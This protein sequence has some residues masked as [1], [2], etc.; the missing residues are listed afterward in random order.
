MV[1]FPQAKINLGLH[2]TE[3]RP[4]GYHNI[5]TIF[6]PIDFRDALEIVSAGR[7]AKEDILTVTGIQIEGSH[8]NNLVITAVRKFREVHYFPAVKIH[9]HK[10]IPSGA[11]LGGGS[12]DAASTLKVINRSLGFPLSSQV[13]KAIALSIGSDCPFFIDSKP[14]FAT[15][16]GEILK[17]VDL[18][19]KGF[20]I[21]LVNPGISISTREAY[22]NCLPENPEKKLSDIIYQPVHLWKDII[23]ND[24]EKYV[25]R[26]YPEI[27]EIKERLYRSG[28]IYSS[29]SGSGST[30]YGIFSGKPESDPAV[31]KNVIFEGV[32]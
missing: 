5:E 10:A 25:F 19:L 13:L 29:M 15:G 27:G 18:S 21:I 12:S 31:E 3:K 28:A 32:I 4:D 20:Y 7:N 30:L 8:E 17:P 24:F 26:K 6:Y 14:S 1:I 2:V 16:R 9:L 22:E 23:I 11:G